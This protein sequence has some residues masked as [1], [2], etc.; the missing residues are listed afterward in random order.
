MKQGAVAIVGIGCR[1]PGGVVDTSSFW[2]LL[3]E[4][5]DAI[6][7]VPANRIDLQQFF[8]PRPATP[9]R[10]MSRRGGFLDHIEDFDAGFFGISPR[11]AER[12]DPQQRLLLEVAWEAFED[13]GENVNRL[14]GSR[15]GVYVGQWTSDFESRLFAD[16]EAVDFQMTT[17]SGRY[18][19]SGRLSY[20]FGLRGPSMTI[21]SACSSSLAAVHLAVAAIR[22]G[23]CRLALAGGVNM[24]LQPHISVAYSQ[25]RMMAPDGHCKFGDASGDGYVRSEGA[26]LVLLKPLALAL[27][28]G[29]RIHAVVRGSAVNNDGSSSGVLGRPSRIGHEEMLRSAYADAGVAPSQV[30]YVEAHGTGTRAGD[31]VELA[32]LGAVIGAERPASSTCLVGSVKTNIG[33]TE[34]AAGI[35]GLIKAALALRHGVI[36]ASLHFVDPNP[37]VP[38]DE[39]PFRVPTATSAWP[40]GEGPRL[41]GVNSFGISGSNAH[42]VLEE[43]PPQAAAEPMSLPQRP[44]LLVLSARSEEALR[45]LAARHAEL[46]LAADAP[47]LHDVCWQ[48]ATRRTPLE[49]RAAFVAADAT[50]MVSALQRFAAGEMADAATAQGTV[51]PGAPRK[52][53]F[54]LPGQG[55]QWAGMARE[56]MASEPVFDAALRACD[57][58]A[59]P[60]LVVSIRDQLLAEPGSA[61]WQ[62]DRIDVIQPVLV[63]IA[64]ALAQWWRS[65]SIVPDAVVGH[66]MG[67][68]AAAHLAGVLDLDQAM[69]IICRRSALMAATSGQGAMAMV[70]LPMAEAERRLAGRGALCQQQ[71]AVAASNSP[72]ACVLSGEPAA[73][74]PGLSDASRRERRALAI[75]QHQDDLGGAAPGKLPPDQLIAP[76]F[77]R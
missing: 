55:A 50:K 54:V 70:E 45:A 34:S 8:D 48:A 57:A 52:L 22:A 42:V 63:A 32:A 60:W 44:A 76:F 71:V 67:E 73:Q 51:Y 37:G 12:I 58:A 15:T 20:V 6:T 25:S 62:L 64:I 13:A 21:D 29:D 49:R 23:E 46:L 33:H 14:E 27:A 59:H 16:P 77:R 11:E 38:W 26:A 18:A 53:V 65:L 7:E 47:A 30:G 9:G 39:L 69:R 75:A 4:G 68:V 2:K 1:F 74:L 31:P 40:A 17:G 56:L 43:A 61:A 35:A 3:V 41:A 66:S 36:P 72:S 19:A 24:I 28:D 10:M 5:R